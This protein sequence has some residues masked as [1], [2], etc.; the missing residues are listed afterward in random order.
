[1]RT[2][3]VEAQLLFSVTFVKILTF[4]A[5]PEPGLTSCFNFFGT[6]AV[7]KAARKGSVEIHHYLCHLL[8]NSSAMLKSDSCYVLRS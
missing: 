1:M 4:K 6:L 3:G 7:S 8:E 2:L 5:A